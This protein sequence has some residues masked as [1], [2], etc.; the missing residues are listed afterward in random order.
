MLNHNSVKPIKNIALSEIPSEIIT[1]IGFSSFLRIRE[2][3]KR[4]ECWHQDVDQWLNEEERNFNQFDT[5]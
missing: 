1:Y 2:I 3:E 4:R 5:I